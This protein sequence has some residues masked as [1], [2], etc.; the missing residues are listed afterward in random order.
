MDGRQPVDRGQAAASP[1]ARVEHPFLVLVEGGQMGVV[2]R[3]LQLVSANTRA[4]TVRMAPAM[5]G[6]LPGGHDTQG[7]GPDELRNPLL[8]GVLVVTEDP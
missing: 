8:E 7:H 5:R 1:R 4:S 2:S 6:R 3:R